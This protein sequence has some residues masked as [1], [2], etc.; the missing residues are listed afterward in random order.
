MNLPKS[1]FELFFSAII[2]VMIP[3]IAFVLITSRS[4]AIFGIQSFMV[5]S[6]SMSPS[7]NTGNI[8]FTAKPNNVAVGDII[9]FKRNNTNV[10][11][12]VV[13]VTD[14]NGQKISGLMSPLLR[15]G[16]IYYQTKGDANKSIDSTLVL[17]KDLVGRAVFQVPQLGKFSA[18][19]RSPTGFFVFI[20]LPTIL[21]IGFEL[22]N[23]K[24]EIEKSIEERFR[25]QMGV[26]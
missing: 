25:R 9:T 17:Q 20:L 26:I 6:G 12:R 2:F 16:G 5:L 18:F 10:T 4:S 7:I 22:W 19:L 21:F 23:I 1:A 3:L 11:H 13:A 24:K 14:R 15:G 8:V